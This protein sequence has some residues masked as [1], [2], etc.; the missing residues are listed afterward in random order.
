MR[1]FDYSSPTTVDEAMAVL[2]QNGYHHG[3]GIRRWLV[4][5]LLLAG[6]IC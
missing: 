4:C 2:G 1:P 5:S 3:P 6:R